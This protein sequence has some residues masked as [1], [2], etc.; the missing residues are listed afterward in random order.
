VLQVSAEVLGRTASGNR[1]H[2]KTVFQMTSARPE[3]AHKPDAMIQ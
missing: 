3:L 2:T 1:A